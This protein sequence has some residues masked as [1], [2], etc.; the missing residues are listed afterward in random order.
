[1]QIVEIEDKVQEIINA[2]TE[3]E[4][5]LKSELNKRTETYET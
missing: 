5:N 3:I 1:L 4:R 2:K